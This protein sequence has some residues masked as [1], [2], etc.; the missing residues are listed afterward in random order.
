MLFNDDSFWGQVNFQTFGLFNGTANPT[1]TVEAEMEL[2]TL[3][4][5]MQT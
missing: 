2:L 3:V 1:D 4:G 5:K